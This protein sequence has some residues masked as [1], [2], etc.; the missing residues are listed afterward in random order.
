[1]IIV[2]FRHNFLLIVESCPVIVSIATQNQSAE[3]KVKIVNALRKIH[4]FLICLRSQNMR[5]LCEDRSNFQQARWITNLIPYYATN[6]G[7]KVLCHPA[8]YTKHQL[9]PMF[10]TDTLH[11]IGV[12]IVEI[13]A[14]KMA[15]EGFAV[16]LEVVNKRRWIHTVRFVVTNTTALKIAMQKD[17]LQA[18]AQRP[19]QGDGNID[20]Q[21]SSSS[22]TSVHL[23][24]FRSVSENAVVINECYSNDGPEESAEHVVRL[25]DEMVC[26]IA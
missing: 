16:V 7:Q 8:Y 24:P 11:D 2:E 13:F 18:L 25:Y 3:V 21:L 26:V 14:T 1:M 19:P 6:G 9:Q 22:G 23:T 12:R 20:G 5:V 15:I 17:Q 4:I 10:T